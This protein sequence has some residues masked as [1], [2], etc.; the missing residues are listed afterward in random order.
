MGTITLLLFFMLCFAIKDVVSEKK[1]KTVHTDKQEDNSRYDLGNTEVSGL[2]SSPT[3]P[4]VTDVI[5]IPKESRLEH[6]KHIL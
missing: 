2:T 3:T 1:K 5:L 4:R 6:V